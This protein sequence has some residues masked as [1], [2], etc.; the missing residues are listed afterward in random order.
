MLIK[1]MFVLSIGAAVLLLGAGAAGAQASGVSDA[2]FD[3]L[4][5]G[6]NLAFWFWYAPAEIDRRFTDEDF[7]LIRNLGFTF[8]R[9]P[10]DLEFVM[11][12]NSDDLLNHDNLAYIDRGFERLLAHDLAII[13]DLHS[14]SLADSDVSNYSSALEDPAF[15]EVFTRFWQSF[16]NYLANER[17]YDPEM[18]FFGP[19]NEPV[20]KADPSEWPPIQERLLAAIRAVAPEHTLIATG[21]L[22][23]SLYTLLELQPLND[24]NIVY[25]FHFYEPFVFTHQGAGWTSRDV[26]PLREVPYPSSP[27]AVAPLLDGLP[28]IA[29]EALERYGQEEWDAADL[30]A[31]ISQVG[32]WAQAHGLRVICTEFG[33]YGAYA[34]HQDRVRWIT[35]TRVLLEKY[36]LG[37]GMWEYDD[38]FGLVQRMPSGSII[39][40]RDLAAALG[41]NLP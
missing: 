32:A 26:L 37:W 20:F 6:I 41:L 9:V 10:I 33:V 36:G 28:D 17:G 3:R 35:D 27:E 1:R 16:A 29:R 4:A 22:W 40:Q 2:R 39:L 19:M 13:V 21:A 14:T 25:D 18:M 24:P 23:S 15:V 34:P 12:K 11:D 7:A 5:R 30:E 31:R 38:S 8:V